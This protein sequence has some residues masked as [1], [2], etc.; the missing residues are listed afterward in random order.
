MVSWLSVNSEWVSV[1]FITKIGSGR[2]DLR[3]HI[4]NRRTS[5]KLLVYFTGFVLFGLFQWFLESVCREMRTY[6]M[7]LIAQS[8]CHA[9][10]QDAVRRTWKIIW[11]RQRTRT[12]SFYSW[13]L[14]LEKKAWLWTEALRWSDVPM[15]F[16]A[17]GSLSLISVLHWPHSSG[18]DRA[19][20]LV[21]LKRGQITWSQLISDWTS[22]RPSYD[23][24]EG[25]LRARS[26]R[27]QRA[28]IRTQGDKNH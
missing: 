5:W 15:P 4:R 8:V 20:V 17:P 28:L 6:A 13:W 10:L 9:I 1:D 21:W 27:K 22:H 11:L 24:R 25:P 3:V 26:S 16:P 7:S 19:Q 23:Q 18:S 14:C 2:K 12:T